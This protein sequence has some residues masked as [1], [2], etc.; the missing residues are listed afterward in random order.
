MCTLNQGIV[1]FIIQSN[2]VLKTRKI[3]TIHHT[4][5]QLCGEKRKKKYYTRFNVFQILERFSELW[6]MIAWQMPKVEFKQ[7]NQTKMNFFFYEK[8][9]RLLV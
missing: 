2:W 4:R 8:L 5:S 7:I 9:L 1:A 6:S 3:Y